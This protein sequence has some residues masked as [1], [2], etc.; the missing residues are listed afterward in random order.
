MNLNLAELMTALHDASFSWALRCCDFKRDLAEE[1]L[2]N[3]YLKVLDNK[4]LFRG[5]SSFKTWLFSVIRV[6]AHEMRRSQMSKIIGNEKFRRMDVAEEKSEE[7]LDVKALFSELSE[8]QAQ[9][10]E[11]V[12]YHDLTLE[13]AAHTMGISMGTASTHY[14]RAKEILKQKLK[15]VA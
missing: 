10:M 1:V 2:Q 3:V 7:T 9:L 14:K 12:F 4:A 11:L 5:E 15:G 6:T 13:E 8:K